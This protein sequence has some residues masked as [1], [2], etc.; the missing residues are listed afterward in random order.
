MTF[1]HGQAISAEELERALSRE[2][3]PQRF[4]SLCNAVAWLTAGRTLHSV[5][6]FTER[7]NV[8]DKG[9]DA[10]LELTLPADGP[11]A[12]PYLGP[13]LNVLQFK[14]RDVFAQGRAK[15]V[16]NLKSELKGALKDLAERSG[17]HPDRYVVFTN[18]DLSHEEKRALKKAAAHGYGRAKDTHIEIVGAAE[19][20]AAVNG[21]PHVRSGYFATASFSSWQ[22]AKRRHTEAKVFGGAVTLVGRDE[23]MAALKELVDEPDVRAV[24][25]TGPHNIG[26]SRL[27]LEAT[28]H[29]FM[30]V[31]V[32]LGGRTTTPGD[33][34]SMVTPGRVTVVL[35]DD[36]DPRDLERL[37]GYV[38]GTPEL[39]LI[40]TLPLTEGN[41]DP[42]FGRDRRVRVIPV[43]PL[44]ETASHELLRAAGGRF[45][46]GIEAW[47][48][49]QAGG[50]P[51]ILL[52]AAK[53]GVELRRTTAEFAE[54][55]ARGFATRV[56]V[57]LGDKALEALE[58]LSLMT[59]L[60]I[61]AEVGKELI[62]VSKLFGDGLDER[63]VVK[64]LLR[65][66]ESGVVKVTGLFAEVT[67]PFFANHLATARLRG[68]DAELVELF[69][70]LSSAGRYRL[71]RR[72]QSVKSE[73]AD[74]FWAGL[75]GPEGPLRDLRT[76]LQSPH[77][78]RIVARAAPER[79]AT[80]IDEGLSAMSRE[81]RERIQGE[82]RR[83][84]MWALDD[85]LFRQQTSLQAL[86][87]LVRLAEVETEKCGNNATGVFGEAFHWN[88]P[89]LPLPLEERL[90]I[91]RECT[92]EDAPRERRLV[93]VKAIET[94][95][96]RGVSV[97]LRRGGGGIPLD[98]RPS[99][100]WGEAWDFIEALLDELMA[101]ARSADEMVAA[102]ALAALPTALQ[103]VGA[104]GRR[105]KA[106][107]RIKQ[108]VRWALEEDVPVS[109]A[110][111]AG[112][113]RF[114]RAQFAADAAR[115]GVSDLDELQAAVRE[116]DELLEQLEKGTFGTRLKRWAGP[117][118]WGDH[119]EDEQG[120]RGRERWDDELHTLARE[121]A[122]EPAR[123][124][125]ELREWLIS[126]EAQRAYR[127]FYWLGRSDAS[128]RWLAAM[129]EWGKG[130]GG[131]LLAA[132][133]GGLAAEDPSF[134]SVKLDELT[135]NGEISGRWLVSATS[136]FPPDDAALRRV[137]RLLREGR[138]D[139]E[140]T[141][142]VLSG[143]RWV[144]PLTDDRFLAL[145]EAI[146]GPEFR[147]AVPVVD[148]LGMWRH[149]GRPIEGPLAEF[150]WRCLESAPN[151]TA[152]E[153][154]DF[155]QLAAA[156]AQTDPD[157]GFRLLEKLLTQPRERESWRPTDGYREGSFWTALRAAD[158]ERALRLVFGV[159]TR[160]AIARLE[161]TWD[162]RESLDQ[163]QDAEI[164]T[165]L[166]MEDAG[167]AELVTE[168]LTSAKPGFWPIALKIAEKYPLDRR[169]LGNLGSG[170]EQLGSLIQGPWSA[171]LER[172]RTEVTG[173]LGQGGMSAR[174]RRWLE[175]LEASFAKRAKERLIAEAAEDVNE[176][177]RVAENPA[178]PERLWAI[179][180]LVVSNQTRVLHELI[181]P[182]EL[183][184]LIPKLTLTAK[185]RERLRRALGLGAGRVK[186][187]GRG[188]G[189]TA[190]GRRK[191]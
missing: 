18:V 139:P 165:T 50:N 69:A 26:K 110:K 67:P 126:P 83:E 180:S 136:S 58:V 54:D 74:R 88:H 135:G 42:N 169:I 98:A 191:G 63:A 122:E 43:G 90:L 9:I 144:E 25:L 36:L 6:S 59:H 96:R 157:R 14:Q 31:V 115:P 188:K 75:S 190:G 118:A 154:Y 186:R 45:D 106:M 81:E 101:L 44:S 164:L 129:E 177:R 28:G 55:V 23:E 49:D 21:L 163:V 41:P 147:H 16:T 146:A 120:R 72:L 17:T 33:L 116:L 103:S 145:L 185:E 161:V 155:D 170:I 46:F 176:L 123:L 19:L 102:A 7:V 119:E 89:Q 114:V 62:L 178:A 11:Y 70:G 127:F 13:G 47:V 12:S 153:T 117:W 30:E 64:L 51:G 148:F 151:V 134:V 140:F 10:E 53:A 66:Q 84:V 32:A 182:K 128:R 174:V 113:L 166:A 29:R 133:L 179:R 137:S 48:V 171:H 152:N 82:E 112:A 100:T 5:P 52:A 181:D 94:G 167:Q 22:E 39:R 76:A 158:R 184:Q 60:G 99:M 68:R 38:L 107:A 8:K 40:A 78:L 172:C 121:A 87:S 105:A 24:V 156:L 1:I 92:A 150:A 141:A 27:A 131:G 56:R 160:D 162:L 104:K 20:T 61:A 142:S 86:R 91:L 35:V 159:A 79:A 3:T 109:I 93:A 108:V 173:V 71:L 168:V 57:E 97:M 183:R 73:E 130:A 2:L 187:R 143:G 125:P 37:V 132:Y 85:L 189:R 111:L 65:L 138:V 34:A 15:T 80:I 149:L 124:M 4:T 77:F 175:G 95:L